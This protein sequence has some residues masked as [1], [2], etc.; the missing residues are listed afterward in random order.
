MKVIEMTPDERNIFAMSAHNLVYD[1]IESASVQPDQLLSE[2]RY[3]DDDGQIQGIDPV[4]IQQIKKDFVTA[5]NNPQKINPTCYLSVNETDVN[6]KSILQ[7]Y[8]PESSQVHRC[9]NRI[10]DR[11]E[12]ENFYI[13][14]HTQ[15]IA[16]VY[17][18]NLTSEFDSYWLT[19]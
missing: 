14:D 5:I 2:R 6:G 9:N 7:I 13:T 18:E 11:N 1:D 16:E 3:M 19:K 10:F 17:P 4:A 12:Y 15:L 8:V